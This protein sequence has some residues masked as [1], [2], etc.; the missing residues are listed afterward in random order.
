VSNKDNDDD[1]EMT[2]TTPALPEKNDKTSADSKT[3]SGIVA[4][5]CRAG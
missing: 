4:G 1:D 5:R 2:E 3:D